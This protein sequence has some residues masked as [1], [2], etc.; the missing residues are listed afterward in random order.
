M[1]VLLE[2]F[3]YWENVHVNMTSC[4]SC[5]RT[6][7]KCLESFQSPINGLLVRVFLLYFYFHY[8]HSSLFFLF[9]M[10]IIVLFMFFL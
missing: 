5:G 4:L 9:L 7:V 8:L 6:F 3:I 1:I 10:E 2:A